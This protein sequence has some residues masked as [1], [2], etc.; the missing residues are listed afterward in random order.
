M[1]NIFLILLMLMGLGCKNSRLS[2]TPGSSTVIEGGISFF[3]ISETNGVRA[4]LSLNGCANPSVALY[5]LTDSGDVRRPALTTGPVLNDGKFNLSL[6]NLGLRLAPQQGATPLLITLE[7][8]DVAFSRPVTGQR[9]QD[10]SH[11]STIVSYLTSTSLR[12]EFVAALQNRA[13]EVVD[14]IDELKGSGSFDDAFARFQSGQSFQRLFGVSPTVLEDAAPIVKT[15]NIPEELREGESVDLEVEAQ[16]WLSSYVLAYQWTFDNNVIGAG[17]RLNWSPRS[18]DQGDHTI[19]LR[20]GR[21]DG[22]GGIDTSAPVMNLS[23]RVVVAN[24]VL[25]MP[26]ELV[27][28][29]AMTG[30]WVVNSRSVSP[31]IN[32]G[33]ELANCESFSKLAL[34]DEDTDVPAP[35]RFVI[36]CSSAVMQSLNFQLTSAGDGQKT[37][38][39]WAIDSSGL[40]S[41]SPSGL[42]LTLDS[43]SP[44]ITL[45]QVPS[46]TRQ[47][48]STMTFSGTDASG[49]A[50]YECSLDDLAWSSCT[51]PVT[52]LNLS[53]GE[54][55]FA[56][57]SIDSLGNISPPERTVWRVDLTPPVATITSTPAAITNQVTTAF[58]FAGT[59]SGGDPIAGYQCSFDGAPLTACASPLLGVHGEGTHMFNVRAVDSAGNVGAETSHSWVVDLT[60]PTVSIT[61]RPA[62]ITNLVTANFVF[63]STDLGGG[64]IAG[65]QCS[66][67]GAD[68]T[69]CSSPISYSALAAGAHTFR[70]KSIDTAGNWSSTSSASWTIDLTPPAVSV[71]SSPNSLNNSSSASFTFT[72]SDS[73]GGSVASTSCQLDSGSF[74]SCASPV[75]YSGLTDGN[76]TFSIRSTDTAGN[77]STPVT[78]TWAVDATAP[79]VAITVPAANGTVLQSSQLASVTISGTCS[80][81]GLTVSVSGAASGSATCT[82]G[83][84]G[85]SFNLS[86]LADGVMSFVA[87]QT[88]V[89][90]NTG[91]SA[92]R[93]VIKDTVLPVISLTTPGFQI[94]GNSSTLAWSLT[95]ANVAS[96]TTFAVELFNG[97]TWS[98]VGTTS[99]TA[100]A[101]A[102]T[103]YSRLVSAL[104]SV[105]TSSARF[106]VSVTDAAGNSATTTSSPFVIETTLPQVST[107]SITQGA[108]TTV[109]NV[110]VNF[111]ASSS[112]SNITEFCLKL[113]NSSPG[114]S[115]SCW[116]SINAT[117]PGVTP[118][119]SVSVSNYFYG[120]G[121]T[122]GIYTVYGFVK[123]A[124]GLISA[125]SASGAGANGV[126]RAVITY[127]SPSAPSVSNVVTANTDAPTSASGDTTVASGGTVIV[128]WFASDPNGLGAQSISLDFTTNGTSYTAIAGNLANG[129]NGACTPDNPASSLDNGNT[130]CYVWSGGAP[131]S[132][133]SVRV[134]A[135]NA[136]QL[137]T[138]AQGSVMNS[139]NI[140]VLVG[141][142]DTGINGSAKSAVIRVRK[143]TSTPVLQQFA[144]FPDGKIV[145]ID[146]TFGL[147]M[148][149]PS[150][151][152]YTTVI[153]NGAT[154][155]GVGDGGS[156]ALAMLRN[157]RYLTIDHQGM[158]YIW[159]HDRIRRVNT[160][161]NP[162]TIS[163]IVGGG[164]TQGIDIPGTSISLA[165]APTQGFFSARPDGKL[166][167][168]ATNWGNSFSSASPPIFY[169]YDPVTA[170]VTRLPT[171]G[172]TGHS[173]N[174]TQNINS[175]TLY[176]GALAMSY[177]T[178]SFETKAVY[179]GILQSSSGFTTRLNP[180]TMQADPSD[181]MASPYGIFLNAASYPTVGLDGRVYVLNSTGY[182]TRLSETSASSI[183]VAGMGSG[184][185][186]DGTLATACRMNTND[187][188]IDATGK[189]FFIDSGMIR[190]IDGDGKVI[191]LAGQPLF[192]GDGLKGTDARIG[193]IAG[194]A[195]HQSGDVSVLDSDTLRIRRWSRS[196][197][198]MSLSAGNSANGTPNTTAAAN[199]QAIF[200]DIWV[201]TFGIEAHPTTDEVIYTRGNGN[202]ISRLSSTTGRWVDFIGGGST[203]YPN[204]D[205]LGFGSIR[206]MLAYTPRVIGIS[207]SSLL[208]AA[209]NYTTNF[210]NNLLLSYTLSGGVQTTLAGQ[211]GLLAATTTFP[212]DGSGLL[213]SPF[214]YVSMVRP[215]S[216]DPGAGMWYLLSGSGTNNRIRTVT[217]GGN[218]GTLFTDSAT[219]DIIAMAANYENNDAV[220]Y[221]CAIVG[222]NYQLKKWT[223]SSNVITTYSWPNSSLSCRANALRYNS[224]NNTIV[225]GYSFGGLQGIAEFTAP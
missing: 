182:I 67:D 30:G 157:P 69:S 166:W 221:Y 12:R 2:W 168:Q 26:P 90:G 133:F 24:N 29:Q 203:S 47:Q 50:G 215:A 98:G 189:V 127:T 151:G 147:T 202:A 210:I 214:P 128:K 110:Q 23:R 56:V 154:T 61:T 206:V 91:T 97:S 32:T 45:A 225:F 40:V 7:G 9:S 135:T 169:V 132:A 103:S 76:H 134:R 75:L 63:S 165:T 25:P 55:S 59:D 158:I 170:L 94:G 1:L 148:I 28:P 41:S 68:F 213:A 124:T 118:A 208:V 16:H 218:Y 167:F 54:H 37:L 145:V 224:L 136:S 130:G 222:T 5:E 38:R 150:T 17:A 106:R 185:C 53:E 88:D 20:V 125:L 112:V 142:L 114:G 19:G 27:A 200:A 102:S 156:V 108:S 172:G 115:D 174:S 89:A 188:F 184:L 120:L 101:N 141:N 109:Q 162:W 180:Q 137:S 46:R 14:L 196:T 93:T 190:A 161:V 95:E 160:T 179:A 107:F 207:S 62:T 212:A 178:V 96:A 3:A 211:V 74:Q 39:L 171:I 198:L 81:N 209:T 131:A 35:E 117:P 34:T 21:S 83:T 155:S 183:A 143:S 65:H 197:S 73:G 80:E 119:T 191:T 42:T 86:S 126:D 52:F 139:G 220:I 82:S 70:V 51:S 57:R 186:V 217:P 181:P 205:G 146:T 122:T 193:N 140:R 4:N 187:V 31:R 22:S 164:S 199:T 153:R 18:N 152:L 15:F 85:I 100:G 195:V 79:T 113:T 64:N 92:S 138:S 36:S 71:T 129:A 204:A 111:Q 44:I 144:V 49:V 176:G 219:T 99:A 8:C 175:L 194:I 163:T 6:K 116:R 72:V 78:L 121:F 192:F 58:Q 173:G 10:L 159:D 123:T 84:F 13:S 177:D 216:Y 87:S 201:N 104:P 43:T 60:A 11:G 33:A 223:R 48:V 77:T 66:L 149:D 105:N